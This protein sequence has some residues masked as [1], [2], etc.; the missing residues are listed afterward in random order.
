MH[1][2]LNSVTPVSLDHWAGKSTI[3]E[4][5]IS[6]ISVRG[7]DTTADGEI[8]GS[9]NTCVGT[10]VIVVCA[11]VESAPGIAIG[12]WIVGKERREEW[13]RQGSQHRQ[14]RRISVCVM[15]SDIEMNRRGRGMYPFVCFCESLLLAI[16]ASL[17]ILELLK[18]APIMTQKGWMYHL[19][20]RYSDNRY[21]IVQAN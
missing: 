9:Y 19:K 2:D 3:D 11:S 14:A 18:E 7:N 17:F 8:I 5:D 10:R 4:E 6:L 16:G 15:L 1:G 13:S 21:A 20:R 12:G